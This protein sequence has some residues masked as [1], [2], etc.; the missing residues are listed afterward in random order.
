M[1]EEEG[2]RMM[3]LYDVQE[4][5]ASDQ[6]S[7]A[8]ENEDEEDEGEEVEEEEE[9][10][11][12]FDISVMKPTKGKKGVPALEEPVLMGS[13]KKPIVPQEEEEEE[14]VKVLIPAIKTT[15]K[16]KPLRQQEE[17]EEEE[18]VVAPPKASLPKKQKAPSP[19]KNNNN[20]QLSASAKTK[21]IEDIFKLNKIK[22]IKV[23]TAFEPLGGG[24][25]QEKQQQQELDALKKANQKLQKKL[26][27]KK[28]LVLELKAERADF[29]K[30]VLE[31]MNEVT[32]SLT[33][34]AEEQ[35]EEKK[36]EFKKAHDHAVDLALTLQNITTSCVHAYSQGYRGEALRQEAFGVFMNIIRQKQKFVSIAKELPSLDVGMETA[37]HFWGPSDELLADDGATI[38]SNIDFVCKKHFDCE[39]KCLAKI[40]FPSSS[41]SSSSKDYQKTTKRGGGRGRG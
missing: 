23:T 31:K 37:I 17:E 29:E 10:E 7:E 25:A 39:P 11:K 41:S 24:G 9:E 8:S 33:D 18:E 38:M 14:D 21:K 26:D 3:M 22:K 6:G 20:N 27:S 36:N 13:K 5:E 40:N 4:S 34:F 2:D 35:F 16:K 15:T 32:Q 12:K 19:A 1:E 28:K 30:Q